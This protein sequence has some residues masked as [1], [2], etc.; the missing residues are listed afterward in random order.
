L[1]TKLPTKE[2]NMSKIGTTFKK[3]FLSCYTSAED[4]GVIKGVRDITVD[5]LEGAIDILEA[6]GKI[7]KTA[8]MLLKEGMETT[9]DSVLKTIDTQVDSELAI[10]GNTEVHA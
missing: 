5:A 1:Q 2:V 9:I 4:K 10:L 7:N 8:A 6:T 3:L